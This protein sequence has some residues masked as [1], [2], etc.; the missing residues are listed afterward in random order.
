MHMIKTTAIFFTMTCLS[1][2]ALS[3]PD[4]S[5]AQALAKKSSCM[6]CHSVDKKKEGPSFQVTAQKYRGKPDAVSTLVKHLTTSPAIKIDGE[7]DTHDNAK[8]K[9]LKE[10]ENLARWILSH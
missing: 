1:P 5:A 6:K 4:V 2:A 3:A 7:D 9:D 10:V 8:T